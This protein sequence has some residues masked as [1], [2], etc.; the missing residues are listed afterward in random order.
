MK[1]NIWKNQ[2]E[3]KKTL[4]VDEYD[5][6]F[7]TIEDLLS[8]VDKLDDL[9]DDEQLFELI[10]ENLPFVKHL[11]KDIFSDYKITDSDL[12]CTKIKEYVP[13]FID[14]ISYCKNNIGFG[15]DEKN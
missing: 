1:L 2:K 12:K 13:L 10:K 3:I 15:N 4:E 8:I 11:I 9:N 5:I 14:L 6:M 7:G